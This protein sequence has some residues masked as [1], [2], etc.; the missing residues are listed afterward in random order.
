MQ[1]TPFQR[2]TDGYD[3][4]RIPAITAT[5]DAQLLAICEG[6]KDSAGD[7]GDIDIVCRRSADGGRTWGTLAVIWDDGANTCG[8]PC[9]VRDAAT[10]AIWLLMTWNRGGDREAGIIAETSADT[11]HVFVS[12]SIDD[13]RSFSPPRDITLAVKPADWTWYATG[14][15]AGIQLQR[16]AHAGRLVIPCDHIEAGSKRYFAHVIHSDDHGR[17]WHRGG[18]TPEPRVNECE[19]IERADAALLLNMRSYDRSTKAR[20]TAVSR[21]GG[22]TWS[23]QRIVPE[24]V[25]PICQASIRRLSWPRDG[26]EG[27]VLF[28]NAASE[29]RE[30]MTVRAS[31]DDGA[32]WPVARMLSAQPAAYSCL[33]AMPGGEV[34]LLYETGVQSPYETIA[35][36]SFPLAWLTGVERR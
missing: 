27:V 1:S 17:S 5:G 28:A 6:R 36:T 10:G 16:G 15:G 33:V 26:S 30:R 11:R 19:V 31:F 3:T 14:P 8:N 9:V 22:D 12:S 4:F 21:D 2:G 23:E 18:S 24:L 20:Q 35:F 34:G 25:D 13:G 29:R 32:S 7:S